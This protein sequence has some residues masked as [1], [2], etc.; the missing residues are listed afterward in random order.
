M[1]RLIDRCLMILVLMMIAGPLQA[2]DHYP[3]ELV[4]IYVPS[5]PGGSTDAI[6]RVFAKHFEQQT[7]SAVA[8]VNQT[9]GGGVIAAHSVARSKPNGGT[10]LLYHTALHVSHALGRSPYQYKDFTPLATL[11]MVNDVYAV[12]AD[13]PYKTLKEV[14][15]YTR[16]HEGKI[17]VGSQFGA[18]TQIKG[19]AL[20]Q[21]YPEGFRVVDS[22]S[23]SKRITALLGEKVDLISMSVASALQFER[24]GD[25]RILGVMNNTPDPF[26]P[27]W[28]TAPSQGVPAHLPQVFAVYGPADLPTEVIEQ[29]DA[30]MAKIHQDPTYQKAIKTVRQSPEYRNHKDAATFLADEYR[31][32]EKVVNP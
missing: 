10:L 24:N 29:F 5:S 22:G 31:F 23:E 13:A 16:E 4:K 1:R 6:A 11:S 21:L 12:R 32:I 17:T 14:L 9:G 25:V 18:T 28:P 8:I 7:G 15:D 26:A 30:V 20:T 27:D 19:Q 2:D 3:A